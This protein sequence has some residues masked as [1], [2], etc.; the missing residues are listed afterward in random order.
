M[1]LEPRAVLSEF[2]LDLDESIEVRVWDSSSDMRYMVLPE[3]PAGTEDLD[4]QQL[5]EIVSREAMI[6]VAQVAA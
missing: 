3:R 1:V 5:A 6:G 2:G 4:E